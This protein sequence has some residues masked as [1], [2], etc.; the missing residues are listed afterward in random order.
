MTQTR[1]PCRAGIGLRAPHYQQV[2]QQQPELGWV[3]VHSENFFDGGLPL[4]MLH[5]VAERYPLSLHGVGLGLG[6]P[7]RPEARHLASLRRLVDALDPAAVSEHLCLNHSATRFVNDL[8]PLPYTRD[9]LEAVSAHVAETQDALRRPILLEN[10]SSYVEYPGNEMHEGEF[11]AELVKRTGCGILLDLNNLYVNQVNLGTDV[12]AVIAALP[13]DA[14]GEIHLAGY[15]ERDGLLVDTHS[16]PVYAAVWQLYRDTVARLG[17]RPTLI[18]W[19]IDI[20]SLD[21][22]CGEAAKA[23]AIL[24]ERHHDL[25]D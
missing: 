19:D 6:S 20:P 5:R 1:L 9:A 8:L 23:Q 24:Q 10:L 22:L 11:L 13:P 3:E 15:S 12:D 7:Q 16:Q 17:P 4:A 18:E 2:L 21:V 25:V 14:I